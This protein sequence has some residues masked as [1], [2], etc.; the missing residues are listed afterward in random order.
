MSITIGNYNFEGPYDSAAQLQ[1]RSGVYAILGRS[2]SADQWK[3]VDIGESS[4][5]SERVNNHDRAPC[6]KGRGYR[7]LS[8]AAYYCAERE[9][10]AVERVLRTQYNP[11]CGDR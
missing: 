8:A 3:M 2:G 6:W 4:G 7:H 10:M 11:P 1:N 9:R 5:V